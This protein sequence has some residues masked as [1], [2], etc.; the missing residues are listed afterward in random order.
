MKG[1]E[2]KSLC[3]ILDTKTLTR[4]W[5]LGSSRHVK[6]HFFY[7]SIVS[8]KINLPEEEEKNVFYKKS[9]LQQNSAKGPNDQNRATKKKPKS[10]I[11]L[12]NVPKND[13]KKRKSAA[14]LTFSTKKRKV[15]QRFYPR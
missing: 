4:K 14:L 1:K 9:N 11:K 2:W 10:N 8:A 15:L 3:L 6:R 12:Q 7:T 13:T 5:A